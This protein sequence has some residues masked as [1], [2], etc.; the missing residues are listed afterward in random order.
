MASSPTYDPS[1]YAR[2][3]DAGASWPHQG[4]TPKTALDQN[5]PALNRALDGTYP[6]GS[7]FKPL[8]AIAALQ[9]HIDQAVL[10]LAVHGLVRGS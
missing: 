7:V 3:R 2:P 10:A 6:P 8:T 4:L 9:E 1:V 5:Y